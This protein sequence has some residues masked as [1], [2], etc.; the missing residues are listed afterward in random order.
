MGKPTLFFILLLVLSCGQNGTTSD[1]DNPSD[2]VLFVTSNAKYYGESDI[3]T[4]NNF[5]EIVYAYHQFVSAEVEVDFVSPKGGQIPIGYIYSSDTLL[6]YYLFNEKLRL[7]L[8][9]TLKPLEVDTDA[10]SAMYY[11][12]GGSAMFT[13]PL[14][15]EIQNIAQTI[16]EKNEGVIS[17]VCHGTAGIAQIQKSDG[18]FLVNGK[19]IS[20]FP[21]LFEDKEAKYYQEFPFSIQE[22]IEAN[23]GHFKYSEEGWDNYA[24]SDGR[25]ITGQDPTGSAAVAKMVIAQIQHD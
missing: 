18:S 4:T 19:N 6:Q 14:N 10:Y 3:E 8:Q 1:R 21:D 2:K 15:T 22:R 25:L 24:I 12:G 9:H 11:V 5:P 13:V 7:K 23:G 17:A 16:Y 20:G